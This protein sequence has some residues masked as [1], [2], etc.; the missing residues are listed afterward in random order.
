[1]GKVFLLNLPHRLENLHYAGEIIAAEDRGAVG[2]DGSVRLHGDLF[3]LT[4][5]DRVHMRRKQDR[6][7]GHFSRQKS[8]EAAAVGLRERIVNRN[9]KAQLQQLL[10]QALANLRL[11]LGRDAVGRQL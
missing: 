6:F 10:H 9:R 3:I 8:V 2:V 11:V 7:P 4:G 1:M 5:R